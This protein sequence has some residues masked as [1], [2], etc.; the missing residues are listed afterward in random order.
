M[1]NIAFRVSATAA[2]L[3]AL[4][5]VS[6]APAAADLA[7]LGGELTPTGAETAASADGLVPAWT[8]GLASPP[9]GFV[10]G[11]GYV[12]PFASDKPLYTITKANAAQ[13][14]ELL[15]LGAQALL[16]RGESFKMVVYPSHRTAALPA[17]IA[18]KVKEQA[19]KIELQG[20]GPVNVAGSTTPFPLP[21]SGLEVIWNHNLRYLGGGIERTYASF[22]V[23]ANGDS[24]AIKVVERRVFSQNM[25]A[26]EPNRLLYF[27]SSIVAPAAMTGGT[28][29]VHE[30]LDQVKEARSA[31]VY[32]AGQR[33]VRRAP[34]LA[35]DSVTDDT[36]GMRFVDQYDAFNGAPDRFDFKLVGKKAMLVPYNAYK[37]LDKSVPYAS[38][39]KPGSPNPELMRYEVHRVWVVDATLKAGQKHAFS[40]RTFY[41]DEDSWSVLWEDAYDARG[42]LWR[43][44]V[45]P[46]V[47]F[48]D[49]NVMWYAVNI[50]HD[51][52]NGGY[53]IAALGGQEAPPRFNIK[54]KLADFQP[55]AMRRS[56]ASQ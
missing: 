53:F 35:Y 41:V 32:N 51:L 22:P 40:R 15:P 31:W 49:A 17:A 23:R 54:G 48:Y 14:K 21:K 50:W 9:A 33:R 28:T 42:G 27:V 47:Q 37:L 52:S 39:V 11:K 38:I 25:D 5:S 20:F 56:G 36:E 8:G 10:S 46:V 6:A 18:H 44:G 55:D 19:A 24:Y 2:I 34:D 7:K 45:H 13:Y 16:A 26:P 43:V 29:L 4:G 1:N 30:P 12:D 3:L